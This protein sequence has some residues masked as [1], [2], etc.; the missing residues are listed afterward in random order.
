MLCGTVTT[1]F[2]L[3][4]WKQTHRR[5]PLIARLNMLVM[6]AAASASCLVPAHS[7]V[8]ESPIILTHPA[9][10]APDHPA[11]I[12]FANGVTGMPS[13]IYAQPQ[14]YRPLTLDLYLPPKSAPEPKAG[15][16]MVVFIHGGAWIVGDPRK[17]G[18]F[19]DFPAVLA[20]I[21]ARGY[22]IASI[23]YRLSGEAK[24]PSQIMDVRTAIRWLRGRTDLYHIDP[25]KA[26]AWG[27]SAGG[28]LATLAAT[29][30]Q[31]ASFDPADSAP[32][33]G[34]LEVQ[35][36]AAT[37][38]SPCVQGAVAWYGAFDLATIAGQAKASNIA[39]AIQHDEP[40]AAEWQLLG[41]NLQTCD[42]EQLKR[43]SPA[44]RVT[45][46]TPPMLLIAGTADRTIP[47]V[48]SVEMAKALKAA[49]V[50]V[51]EIWM[52]GIDHS[53]LG[54]TPEKTRTATLEALNA[55]IKWIDERVGASNSH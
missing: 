8:A 41:C 22:V 48:Q 54:Q 11:I 10:S 7:Q 19:E 30:C 24:F 17:L 52:E 50:P 18:A 49:G 47:A 44:Q 21:A 37:L 34:P 32:P 51:T 12:S 16:P 38:A 2:P 20:S 55:T 15:Y 9:Q 13:L 5:R 4:T 25:A 6:L 3:H 29:S 27:V 36:N 28:H 53:F 42:P 26:V 33:S 14:G 31:D 39:G 1:G 45:P 23:S 40:G 43:A 46:S 35:S